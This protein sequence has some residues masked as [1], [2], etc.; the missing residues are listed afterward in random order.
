MKELERFLKGLISP[1]TRQDYEININKFLEFK[2]INNI[3]EFKN[4]SID[5]VEDWSLSLK[6]NGNSQNTR[7][8]RLA[9]LAS[10]CDYL[11]E[12]DVITKNIARPL[13]KKL[14]IDTKQQSYLTAG[15]VV[16]MLSKAR[17]KRTYA[18]MMVAVN[19]GIRV[20]ELINLKLEDYKVD[21]LE[22]VNGK[23][24]KSR[25]VY[26]NETTKKALDDYIAIRKQSN[27]KNLFISDKCTPMQIGALNVT[28][29]N[30][31]S[32]AN[33]NKNISM[34]SLRRSLATDLYANGVDLI[35]ISNILGHSAI[36][37]TQL[38][39]KNQGAKTEQ[40]MKNHSYN[41]K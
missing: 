2:N 9:A 28:L 30:L 25:V 35:G 27:Y 19:T 1:R 4:L 14:K 22:I 21:K 8:V 12:R 7:R 17:N 23:G 31:V 33:I 39:I 11:I 18:I 20:S 26:L 3:E 13:I 36:S 32:R 29:K 41:I 16:K 37:N 15:E 6:E 10:F 34:H 38:Y 40:L 24:G 5:D